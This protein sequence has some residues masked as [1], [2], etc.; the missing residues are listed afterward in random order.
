MYRESVYEEEWY[1]TGSAGAQEILNEALRQTPWWLISMAAHGL[2]GIVL[3]LAHFTEYESDKPVVVETSLQ[4]DQPQEP[5]PELKREIWKEDQD[6][7]TDEPSI[8]DQVLKD[9]ELADHVETDNNE[10]YESSKGIE[11]ARSDKPFQG[12]YWNGSIGIGGGAGGCFGGRFGG[13]RDLTTGTGGRHTRAAAGLGLI[14]LANHQNPDGMWSCRKFMMNCKR[15]SCSGPGERE[16]YDMGVTG[17]STLAFLGAGYTHRHGKHKDTVKR[18]LRAMK[19][20]QTPDGC[21]GPK[22]ADGHWIYNHAICTMAMAEAFGM[23]NSNLLR[24]SAQRAVD[25]LIECRNPYLGWRYGQRPGDNDS[26]VTGWAVLA[27]KSAKFSGLHVPDEAFEGALKW[28]DQVTDEG[29]Y[30]TGYVSKGDAGG[31]PAGMEGKFQCLHAMTAAAVISRIFILDKAARNRPEVLGGANLLRQHPPKW[32]V[33]GGTIDMYYWY[34]GA[35]AMYQLG[36]KYWKAW[37]NALRDSLIP[38]QRKEGCE[39]GS[40]DP[41]GVW[42]KAGGRVYTTAICTLTLEVYYRYARILSE[43][44]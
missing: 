16:D 34:Y 35:L 2:I 1:G 19:E 39:R 21:F 43:R 42:G 8:E 27:L 5:D 24:A 32:D 11:D 44:R 23:S 37:E 7:E 31:R 33:N 17:L 10:D 9:A 18:A 4:E 28:F 15:G 36:G 14:W 25:F 30:Q 22:S 29:Y 41:V 13:R 40:W 26:S 12:K 20:R 38:T 3:M 6:F